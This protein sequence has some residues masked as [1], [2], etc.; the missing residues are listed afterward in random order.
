MYSSRLCCIETMGCT[1]FDDNDLGSS[2]F[3]SDN[4]KFHDFH[5]IEIP[6]KIS[7]GNG[8]PAAIL[9]RELVSLSVRLENTD[10]AY[11][12]CPIPDTIALIAGTEGEIAVEMDFDSWFQWTKDVLFLPTM[13]YRGETADLVKWQKVLSAL[14][15]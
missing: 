10:S 4:L 11:T 13:N 3:M 15:R 1:V 8:L 6:R 9:S 14:F 12:Y 5:L 2:R 7:A